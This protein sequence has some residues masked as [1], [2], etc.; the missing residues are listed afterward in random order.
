VQEPIDT[1]LVCLVAIANALGKPA[2]LQQLKQACRLETKQS[3]KRDLIRAAK[4]LKLRAKLLTTSPEALSEIPIPAIAC[5]QD[6]T[7]VILGQNTP[8]KVLIVNPL[9]GN[10][11]TVIPTEQFIAQWGGEVLTIKR[12]FSLKEASK[13]FNL[14][15]FLPIL[16]RYKNIFAEIMLASFFLQLFGLI[17]P[18][19]TQVIID[20]VLMDKGVATLD[21]LVVAIVI[22]AIFQTGISGIRTYLSAHTTNR[23]DVIFGTKLFRHIVALP[24]RYFENRRV[25]DT[26]MRVSSM[27]TIREFLTG[28]ALTAV[29]DT[30]FSVLFIAVMFYYSMPLTLISLVAIP[31][32]LLQNIIGTPIF[33]QRLEEVW[34]SG[35]EN[36]AYLVEAIT[37]I[38]TI[39]SLA[40]E[41]QFNH[42]WEQ[43]LA[44]Y[45]T[46]TFD[47]TS[48]AVVLNSTGTVIQSLSSFAILWFGGHMVMEGKLTVGQ[49]IAFQM[50]AAQAN[51]PLLRL[52]SL[53]QTFQQAALSVDRLGDI[54]NTP[55]EQHTGQIPSGQA[56]QGNIV[57]KQVTFRY[58]MV[59]PQVLKGIEMNIQPGTKVGIVGRSGSGKSTIAKLLQR[60]YLPE[61]GQILIDG[62]DIAQMEPTWLRRQIG[63]VLQENYLFSGSVRENIAI[64]KP[65]VSMN[66]V[67]RAA[68]T[69]GAHD[70]ILELSEGYDTAVGERGASLS[71]GQR[72]RIAI[73]RALITNPRIIIFD[74]ATSA[75]DYHSENIIM[76]NLDAITAGRT[77]IMVA[78]RLTTV[79]RCDMI[80][81]IDHG[82]VVEQGSHS[83]LMAA[84]G[85]YYNLYRQQEV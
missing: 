61:T 38:H 50:L 75:L 5:M 46:R 58:N 43:K 9:T 67:I 3:G 60:L 17:T 72:Q 1:G 29:M 16:L 42:K 32:Y 59:A 85:L 23:V 73:A 18:L 4:T 2:D 80:V 25:G 30:L 63:V 13:Q 84:Q 78:H 56:L 45:V 57:M 39:K 62:M 28:S 52:V 35:A 66:E 47:Q 8:Q 81:V 20:K 71:G 76:E 33:R 70:F 19:V 82:Q 41:P 15:W 22:S 55:V 31:L 34:A 6:K 79:K 36:N 7:Y 68:K 48:F 24:L 14:A 77:L 11:P 54:L 21:V 65:G 49:L 83:Q 44:K 27:N 10:V 40:I 12:P 37:G 74:E 26:L 51:A 53:W 64:T 69:A